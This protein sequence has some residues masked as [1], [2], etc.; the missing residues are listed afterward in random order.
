MPERELAEA[1]KGADAWEAKYR[2][3]EKARAVAEQRARD[4]ESAASVAA[5]TVVKEHG[6]NEELLKHQ[7]I[8][9]ETLEN[10]RLRVPDQL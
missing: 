5:D 9:Y 1:K 6:V 8:K 10:L 2:D 7:L 3:A 4:A